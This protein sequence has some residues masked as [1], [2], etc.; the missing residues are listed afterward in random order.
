MLYLLCTG[1]RTDEQLARSLQ[2]EFD[3]A[4]LDSLAG[5]QA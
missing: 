1:V 4:D 2:G 3:R 5:N